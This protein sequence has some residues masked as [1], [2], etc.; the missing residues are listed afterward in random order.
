VNE[1]RDCELEIEVSTRER[2]R[3]AT[4][5]HDGP[6]QRLTAVALKLDLFA[7]RLDAGDLDGAREYAEQARHD[8]AGEMTALRNLMTELRAPALDDVNR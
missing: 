5:L 4:D 2:L 1:T 3:L 8:L 7:M 6:I